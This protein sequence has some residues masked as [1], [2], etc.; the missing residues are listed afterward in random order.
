MDQLSGGRPLF[1]EDV[2]R[3][4]KKGAKEVRVH[5]PQRQAMNR[6]SIAKMRDLKREALHLALGADS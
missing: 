4:P 3:K 6:R 5:V 2:T 1:G